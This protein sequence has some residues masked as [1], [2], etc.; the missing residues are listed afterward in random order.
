MK[1]VCEWALIQDQ[2]RRPREGNAGTDENGSASV[3]RAT[4]GCLISPKQV[5]S[6][7]RHFRSFGGCGVNRVRMMLPCQADGHLLFSSPHCLL[8]HIGD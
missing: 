8:A 5:R 4:I 2:S 7:C 6:K 3:P 1:S